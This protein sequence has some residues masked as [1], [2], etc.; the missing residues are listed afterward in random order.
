MV[1]D[2]YATQEDSEVAQLMARGFTRE[3]A[4]QIIKQTL[5]SNNNNA[6]RTST[7]NNKKNN[8]S[9]PASNN[10]NAPPSGGE[11][12]VQRLVAQGYTREQA[13]QI[14]LLSASNT[15]NNGTMPQTMG[16]AKSTKNLLDDVSNNVMFHLRQRLRFSW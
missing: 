11:D 6:N 3:Q 12:E 8:R 13:T 7:A 14:I 9:N 2:A 5:P 10:K 4:N 15:P 1:A 16:R